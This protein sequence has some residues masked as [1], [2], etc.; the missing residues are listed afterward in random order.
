MLGQEQQ[1]IGR[2]VRPIAVADGTFEATLGNADVG[3]GGVIKLFQ[4]FGRR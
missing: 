4:D 1:N 2:L 3:I